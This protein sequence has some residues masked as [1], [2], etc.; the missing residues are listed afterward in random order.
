ML[1]LAQFDQRKRAKGAVRRCSFTAAGHCVHKGVGVNHGPVR[2]MM[3]GMAHQK[4]SPSEVAKAAGCSKGLAHRSLS[5]GM[6]KAE[7]IERIAENR[8]RKA[9]RE[10]AGFP[11]L[12][13]VPVPNGNGHVDGI[14]NFSTSQ[15]TKEF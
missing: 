9:A 11:V 14:P 12:P 5:R 3:E 1:L 4:E 8:R 15:A 2:P 10:S 6:T 13:V 7:I